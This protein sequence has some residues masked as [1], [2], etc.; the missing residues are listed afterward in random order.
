VNGRTRQSNGPVGQSRSV[1]VPTHL[2]GGPRHVPLHRN[3][4]TA[5]FLVGLLA[6]GLLAAALRPAP[7]DAALFHPFS[8]FPANPITAPDGISLDPASGDIYADG[9]DAS[10]G[11]L[12]AKFDTSGSLV[13]GF[14]AGGTLDGSTTPAGPFV[15]GPFVGLR[16][17]ATDP[18]S[19]DL[20]VAE[21]TERPAEG[22]NGRGIVFKFDPAGN[23]VSGF[24][25]TRPAADGQLAGSE[26]AAGHFRPYGVAV[27]P[28]GGRLYVVDIQL[29]GN[30]MV[31][32]FSSS[33]T[34]ESEFELTSTN[35]IGLAVDSG[36]HVYVASELGEGVGVSVYEPSGA[37][38]PDFGS[39]TGLLDPR[40]SSDVAI[41]PSS[42]DIYV[43]DENADG[44]S[45]VTR[46]D[47]TGT[48]IES[49]GA[50]QIGVGV[51]LALGS[52][53]TVHVTDLSHQ[54]ID[55]FAPALTVP[56]VLTE[57]AGEVSGFSATLHGTVGSAG[58]EPED[59]LAG[60][61][62]EYVSA[63][64]FAQTGFSDLGTGGEAPCVP[65]A[66]AIPDDG[67]PHAVSA[68]LEG[69]LAAGTEYRFRL[70]AENQNA[71]PAFGAAETLTTAPP[72]GIGELSTSAITASTAQL[73]AEVDPNGFDTHYRFEWGTSTTYGNEV[74][75]G[76]EDLGAGT[77]PLAISAPIGALSAGTTYHWR[78]T[79]ESANGPTVSPD[80]TFVFL[81]AAEVQTG[82][83][84]EALRQGLDSRLPDCRAYELV[85]PAQK[86]GALIGAVTNGGQPLVA[87]DGQSILLG[88]AQ[89][90]P[91]TEA[92]VGV[93]SSTGTIYAFDRGPSGWDSLNVT[94][95]AIE[96]ETSTWLLFNADLGTALSSAPDPADG[97]D[98]LLARRPG[99]TTSDLGPFG[100][101]TNFGEVIRP[102]LGSSKTGTADLSHVIYTSGGQPL[103]ASDPGASSSVYEYEGIGGPQP[104]LVGVSGGEGSQDL[105][106]ECATVLGDNLNE[107]P[108]GELSADGR[109]VFFTARHESTRGEPCSK[110]GPP[111]NELFARIDNGSPDARTVAISQPAASETGAPNPACT[112][113]ECIQNTTVAAN[114]R[115]AH[116]LAAAAD[117][118]AVFFTDTQQLTDSA[119]QDPVA[120]D[121][122]S[123]LECRN[124]TGPGGCNLYLYLDPRQSPL[125]GGHLIDVSAGDSSGGGPQ[126]QGLLG[127][128]SDGTH[129][130]F[131]AHGVLTA[132]G[133]SQGQHPSAGADNLYAFGRSASDP[134]GHLAFIATLP[135]SEAN[136]WT[137]A[138]SVADVT[139]DGRFLVFTST[140]ALT[141]DVTRTEGP[142]QIYRYDARSEELA[143]ISVGQRGF[144]DN[145]NSGFGDASIVPASVGQA[146]GLGP[147]RLDP[148]M[149]D[150]G[151]RIFFL[152][153]NA[154]TPGALDD[155][156]TESGGGLA[157]NVYEWEEEGTGVCSQ[158]AGCVY[159][160]SD[161]QDVGARQPDEEFCHSSSCLVGT[162]TSGE[163]VFFSTSDRLVGS[164][165]DTQLDFYDARVG[166]GLSEPPPP[167]S[168]EADSCKGSGSGPAPAPSAGTASFTGPPNP[169]AQ[170]HKKHHKK[171]HHKKK[172]H[173]RKHHGKSN[174]HHG[175]GSRG[176]SK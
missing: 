137:T 57:A 61:K 159:L 21:E 78:L 93:R 141:P 38:D 41:D 119:S 11:G 118:S 90:F 45:Q 129:V 113:S 104:R 62:F 69:V 36:G 47:A 10:E 87:D 65:T 165:T 20:Y 43:L 124:T 91:Q 92:C 6:I 132:S 164:D 147:G 135:A 46:Y 7:A 115:D 5:I 144:N 171:K 23:L 86:N 72:P 97:R 117:G 150:D 158:A 76:G 149:S 167:V 94:P 27:A 14:G 101:S 83:P 120:T 138:G 98:H 16:G 55:A 85:T 3:R 64:A 59:A 12:V 139:P 89:C 70:V 96:H 152:S 22:E 122:A 1:G 19:G 9:S 110:P 163:N 157:G 105:I 128:S 166:G 112:T 127:Y 18:E 131:V 58:T 35:P 42:G 48:L 66:T 81:G 82:C 32:V 17:L 99:G 146:A 153:P 121:T 108:F 50:G 103:W 142:A 145:G 109:T 26:T 95:S 24:G 13:P 31:D 130:Y 56:D 73:N 176:G 102:A 2:T 67:T 77:E 169:P 140:E 175:A 125:S 44:L 134:A 172:H 116:F 53:G 68:R 28:A 173:K 156:P 37:L 170:K 25:D 154:L 88:T 60:C 123:E 30:S 75:L 107:V 168:C 51:F 8:S 52:D 54:A 63:A 133:N 126:V 161:G 143:R 84:N 40:R 106:S 80:Q 34:L 74:P 71:H 148:T 29:S 136:E 155:V 111:V 174:R 4:R 151:S 162:D 114:F 79:A 49:F 100:E 160:I 39:G 15:G 33:G